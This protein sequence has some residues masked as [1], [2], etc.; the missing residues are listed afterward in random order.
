MIFQTVITALE[1]VNHPRTFMPG[2]DVCL[3]VESAQE[4]TLQTDVGKKAA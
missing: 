1:H 4:W 3:E 2:L